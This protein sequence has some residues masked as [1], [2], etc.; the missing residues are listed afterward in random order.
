MSQGDFDSY[1]F[2]P[3]YTRHLPN[4]R[5]F[6]QTG[7]DI[8]KRDHMSSLINF[9]RWYSR[10]TLFKTNFYF[11]LFATCL[12]LWFSRL[13]YKYYHDEDRYKE[14]VYNVLKRGCAGLLE[15]PFAFNSLPQVNVKEFDVGSG[16]VSTEHKINPFLWDY[17]FVLN[18]LNPVLEVLFDEV[19]EKHGK[20]LSKCGIN[21]LDYFLLKNKINKA[22]DEIDDLDKLGKKLSYFNKNPFYPKKRT[23]IDLNDKKFFYAFIHF[24]FLS[25]AVTPPP[26][27]SFVVLLL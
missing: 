7:M 10:R 23:Y 13:F 5:Y 17:E 4:H 8:Y 18:E 24:I 6:S 9:N 26:S 11:P 15:V 16:A 22:L 14:F 1:N 19:N 27:I 2:E 25:G 3:T 21:P 12:E 20:I